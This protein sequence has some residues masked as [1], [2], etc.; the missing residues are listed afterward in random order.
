MPLLFLRRGLINA[1]T[2]EKVC[3]ISTDV[4]SVDDVPKFCQQMG[5]SL[6]EIKAQEIQDTQPPCW[7]FIV[8]KK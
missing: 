4:K 5:H 6:L 1:Q 2:G 3:L 8:A 7:H